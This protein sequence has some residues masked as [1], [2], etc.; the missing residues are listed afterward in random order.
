MHF[1][2]SFRAARWIR[3]SNLLLQAL[4]FLALFGGL[5]YLAL[6]HSWRFDLTANRRHSLSPETKS[7]LDQLERNVSITV[8]LTNDS[9]NEDLTQAYRDISG[10][11]REYVYTTRAGAKGRVEVEYLD[12]YQSRKRTHWISTPAR[13]GG[14]SAHPMSRRI[15][16]PTRSWRL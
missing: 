1:A 5:N 11:L 15:H 7:Y 3:F 8:T 6:N 13:C 10:L 9:D 12:I 4:L 2:D 14:F 16:V